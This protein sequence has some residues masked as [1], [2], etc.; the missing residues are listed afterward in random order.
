MRNVADFLLRNWPLKL[1]AAVLA[2]VLYGGVVLSETT[3]TWSPQVPIEI[4][5]PP[6]D[7]AVLTALRPVTRIEYRAPIDVA[8]RLTSGSFRAFV[9]LSGVR[10]EVGGEPVSVPVQLESVDDGVQITDYGPKTVDVQVDPVV[11]RELT[12]RVDSGQI[13][14]GLDVGP[15]QADPPTV[16]LRGAS[17]RIASVTTATA[18]VAVDASALNVDQEVDV[19]PL[20]G[21]GTLVTGVDVTPPRVRVRIEVARQISTATLPVAP[22]LSGEIDQGYQLGHVTVEPLT[23]VVSGEAPAVEQLSSVPTA[24]IELGGRTGT[25]ELAVELAPPPEVTVNGSES[26]K[27]TLEIVPAPGSRTYETGLTLVGARPDLTYA[28]STPSVL[29]KLAGTVPVLDAIDASEVGALVDVT[30]LGPG[31]RELAVRVDAPAGVEVGAVAPE[32]IIVDIVALPQEPSLPL[33]TDS[34]SPSP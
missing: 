13:P 21:A 28:L 14:E 12:V 26:V 1:G 4:I 17:T 16:A 30:G 2:T 27:I 23:V 10:P 9:D 24:P 7:A 11:T 25:I 18:R 22:Q 3:R 19:V 20:D 31:R 34:P 33:P 32:T 8:S 5:N 29:V 15:A 6:R